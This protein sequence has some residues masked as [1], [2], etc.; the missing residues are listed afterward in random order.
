MYGRVVTTERL[1][2]YLV[3]VVL[4]G[5]GLDAFEPV[6]HTDA[7]VN[8]AIPPAAASY[9]AP[10]DLDDVRTR[11][12]REQH[13][14]R[15]RYT[16]GRWDPDERLLTLDIVAHGAKGV[17]GP[18]AASARPG[19]ALVLTGPNGAY[20]PDPAADWHLMVGDESALSAIAAS[21]EAVPEGAPAVVRLLADGPE[22]WLSLATPGDLDLVWLRR[23][24]D[25]RDA[26]LLPAAVRGL[27]FP[28]GRVQAFVHGE[29]GEVREIRRHLLADRGLARAD[30][31][32]SPYWRRHLTDEAWRAIKPAWNAEVERDVA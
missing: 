15:R 8:V 11:L 30:L 20:R 32:A 16:I 9:E 18:W 29:A 5:P 13:P 21:L 7:Y 23:A 10:F 19:D 6:A 24:G 31:S 28:P 4:G 1:T 25:P 27:V 2:P 3:R 22:H 14:H 12:P 17:G 26:D